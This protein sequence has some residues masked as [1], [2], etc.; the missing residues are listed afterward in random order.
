MT[1]SSSFCGYDLQQGFS[2]CEHVSM[3]FAKFTE[4]NRSF[5]AYD[6]CMEHF[7][8]ANLHDM[9]A[10]MWQCQVDWSDYY[11][12]NK[13]WL[14]E[15]LFSILAVKMAATVK[16]F[17]D[18]GWLDCPTSC[19]VAKD[20]FSTCA[21]TSAIS[22]ISTVDDVN[23]LSPESVNDYVKKL[24]DAICSD[25]IGYRQ[26]TYETESDNCWPTDVSNE[27]LDSLNRLILKTALFPGNY[28]DMASGAAAND[29][30][31]WVM[32]Q[33]FDKAAHAL[34]LSPKYNQGGIEWD[35]QFDTQGRGWDSETPFKYEDFEPNIA[36][37]DL[38][39]TAGFLTNK[40]L[41]SLLAPHSNAIPYVYDQLTHWGGCYFD[42][43]KE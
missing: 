38:E 27:H 29:P 21:C 20:D 26:V 28:G 39:D 34:R 8:H 35:S 10:G 17:V 32:H 7:V 6:E 5:V 18:E 33:F 36:T 30:L 11:E 15:E 12:E 31:F 4:S 25:S 1:R 14:S 22:D 40:M 37:H 2:N 41:W 19:D 16:D 3:C 42:P 24:W 43:M 13:D 23:S 9:H